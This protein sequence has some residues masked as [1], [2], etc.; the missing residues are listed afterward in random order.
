MVL[1]LEILPFDVSF[2][3]FK[4]LSYVFEEAIG[5]GVKAS[6]ARRPVWRLIKAGDITKQFLK[7]LFS[8]MGL[9]MD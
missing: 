9:F 6:F 1:V 2:V 4:T 7:R 8:S 5:F 3:I